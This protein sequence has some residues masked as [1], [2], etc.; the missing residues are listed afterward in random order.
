MKRF[1]PLL[2]AGAALW[3][4][5]PYDIAHAAGTAQV[6]RMLQQAIEDTATLTPPP[7]P[8]PIVETT[9]AEPVQIA[10]PAIV[11]YEEP[12]PVIEIEEP[13]A[14]IETAEP[15][16]K[17]LG[18]VLGNMLWLPTLTVEQHYNDNILAAP[19]NE[20]G[21]LITVIN[22]AVRAEI[23]DSE[24]GLAIDLAYEAR[25]FWEETDENEQNF[26]AGIKG[27]IQGE[28]LRV[29]Y[30]VRY[31]V[32]HE[33]RRDDL[34]RQ[35]PDNPIETGEILAETGVQLDKGPFG[36]L[37][38]G[39]FLQEKFDDG[40]T[41]AGALVVR[42]D[43]DRESWVGEGQVSYAMAPSYKFSLGALYG[44]REYEL[45]NYQGGGFN[46]AYRDSKYTAGWAGL[47]VDFEGILYGD[48]KLGYEN[49][50]YDSN[51]IEDLGNILANAEL[52]WNFT[53]T[54]SLI[55]GFDRGHFEDDEVIDPI[56]RTRTSLT[57]QQKLWDKVVVGMGGEWEQLDFEG[58]GR[59]DETILVRALID[60]L[61]SNN[62]TLGGEY[63]FSTRD[64]SAT[65]F[66]Y[67]RNVW[68]LRLTSRI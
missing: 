63:N 2:L 32:D 57:Y 64:S 62:I 18:F 4:A 59:E 24:H 30:Q 36:F 60:Y 39:R 48:L 34:T 49:R 1:F 52:G 40:T 13:A 65:G 7:P 29:P 22:P 15:Q 11:E 17:P 23:I 20:T 61:L 33:D 41:P 27:H 44:T 5:T 37:V 46:G 19:N 21:D 68:L 38:M 9:E 51:T 28:T 8:P 56:L 3:I 45:Q 14:P 31:S 42:H 55:F 6:D 16:G 54:S 43:A 66:D 26:L 67:D 25:Q 47:N 58:S 53:N 12:A 35:L 10:E 50:D